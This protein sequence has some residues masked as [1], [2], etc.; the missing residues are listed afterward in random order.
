MRQTPIA[1]LLALLLPGLACQ[2]DDGEADDD[3]TS[4]SDD[5]TADDDASDDDTEPGPEPDPWEAPGSEDLDAF[6]WGVLVGDATPYQAMLSARTLEPEVDLVLMEGVEGGWNEVARHEQLTPE[7]GVLQLELTDL[8][9][10][11][12]YSVALYATDGERRSRVTRFRSAP[13]LGT[14]RVI[15]FGSTSGLGGNYP[16][17]NLSMAAEQRY[18]FFFLAGDT[19]YADWGADTGFVNKWKEA[20]S[21]DGLRDLSASTAYIATWDDHEV[22]DN[23]SYD[24]P[25]M[26]AKA[27]EGLAAFRQAVPLRDGPG[28]TL[29]WRTLRWGDAVE[30]FALDCRGE[31]RDGDYISTEQMDWFKAALADSDARF[32]VVL[33]SVPITDLADVVG[34]LMADDRWQGFPQQR[35]EILSFILDEGIDGVVWISGDFH[36]GAVALVDPVGG[37]ADDQWEILTGPSGS[38]INPAVYLFQANERYPVILGQFNYTHFEADPVAGTLLVRFVGD[39]GSTLDELLLEI[40]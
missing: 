11:H 18:D 34:N 17:L 9:Q 16:W 1:L 12:T 2:T 20:L 33:N 13:V 40:E 31:R 5:D 15:R 19:I 30:V 3:T 14:S 29:L 39:D 21:R 32:K 6:A 23:W 37:V 35:D 22:A 25:G 8:K 38:S 26:E 36:L 24:S 28:G 10:D 27:A 4:A 7:D